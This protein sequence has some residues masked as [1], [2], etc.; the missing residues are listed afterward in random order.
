MFGARVDVQTMPP[1]GLID[2]IPLVLEQMIG[3][4]KPTIIKM[5]G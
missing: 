3:K 1:G 2:N 5:I 4:G